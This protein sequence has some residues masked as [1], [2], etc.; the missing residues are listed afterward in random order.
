MAF[1]QNPINGQT[2][3]NALGTQYSYVT[4]KGAWEIASQSIQGNPGATGVVGPVGAT[5]IVGPYG[6]T[7]AIELVISGA[8]YA[9][10]PGTAGDLVLPYGVHFT[11]Y[12]ILGTPTG[13]AYIDIYRS[14]YSTYPPTTSMLITGLL[15]TAA[16]KN[17]STFGIAGCTGVKGDILR[18]QVINNDN[19]TQITLALNFYRT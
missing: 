18:I 12:E 10:Q 4:S 3:T 15:M 8:G 9:I 2:Y 13:S 6:A 7:G 17:Q 19:P 16:I 1:P 11:D 14:S 5:G